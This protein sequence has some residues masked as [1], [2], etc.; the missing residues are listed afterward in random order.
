[1]FWGIS[2]ELKAAL[3]GIL[4]SSGQLWGKFWGSL[5]KALR[6]SCELGVTLGYVCSTARRSSNLTAL[7]VPCLDTF[8]SKSFGLHWRG[9]NHYF[10][11]NRVSGSR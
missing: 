9:P 5:G 3:G 10:V 7:P 2:G 4:R 6:S 11:K 8:F 1:M